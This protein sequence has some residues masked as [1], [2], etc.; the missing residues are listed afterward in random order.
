MHIFNMLICKYLHNVVIAVINIDEIKM[1]GTKRKTGIRVD[2]N[3]TT[4]FRLG[5]KYFL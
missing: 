1:Y 2:Y 5:I 4:L 3:G